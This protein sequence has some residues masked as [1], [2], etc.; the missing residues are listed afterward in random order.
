MTAATQDRNTPSRNADDFE[1]PVAATK[2]LFAGTL[3]CLSATG[4]ATPGATAT[5][6]IAVGRVKRFV[7]NSTGVDG[8]VTVKVQ[9]GCFRFSNSA[10]ADLITLAQVGSTAYIVD[11]S[12]VAKT[13]GGNTRSIA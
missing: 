6:L 4:F 7:D 10:A 9:R 2:K 5:T 3:A 12:T 13:H 1:F 8:D 11:D